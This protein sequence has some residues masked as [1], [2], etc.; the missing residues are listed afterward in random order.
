[1]CQITFICFTLSS[2]FYRW[3]EMEMLTVKMDP[4]CQSHKC[5]LDY[6]PT[7]QTTHDTPA[8]LCDAVKELTDRK[9]NQFRVRSGRIT[10]YNYIY[11]KSQCYFS[12]FRQIFQNHKCFFSILLF[13]SRG[14]HEEYLQQSNGTWNVS[15]YPIL[16]FNL[17]MCVR[18]CVYYP[19]LFGQIFF[20]VE[21]SEVFPSHLL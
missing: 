3:I 1:M 21:L 13:C 19:L 16:R 2:F 7:L 11:R 17:C 12:T 6:G 8:M 15:Y 9:L 5:L 18:V 20:H 14:S 10:F 4:H